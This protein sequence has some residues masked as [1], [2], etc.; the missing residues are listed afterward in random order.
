MNGLVNETKVVCNE[1]D[2]KVDRSD[3]KGADWVYTVEGDESVELKPRNV[4]MNQMP[5]V[6][7]M[8]A[9]DAIYLIEKSGLKTKLKGIG[10]VRKQFPEPGA[11]CQQGQL[12][13]LDLS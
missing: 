3:L 12:V 7:G 10:K 1:L 4:V 9:S 6:L 2:I 5:N 11:N 8:G 13:Y